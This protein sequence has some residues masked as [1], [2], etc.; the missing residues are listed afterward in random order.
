MINLQYLYFQFL[1]LLSRCAF[2]FRGE[3]APVTITGQGAMA[4][5]P[6]VPPSQGLASAITQMF[7]PKLTFTVNSVGDLSD[8]VSQPM[9][10]RQR[11]NRGF[12]VIASGLYRDGR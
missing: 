4:Q 9:C 7:P 12:T 6:P 8:K 10:E 5:R 2:F 3:N 1:C 11:W